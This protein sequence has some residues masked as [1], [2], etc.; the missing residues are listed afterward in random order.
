MMIK[1]TF[2]AAVLTALA[3]M[4][5][6]PGTATLG[7]GAATEPRLGSGGVDLRGHRIGTPSVGTHPLDTSTVARGAP[8]AWAALGPPGGDVTDVAASPVDG[9]LVIAVLASSNGGGGAY[10][11]TD[12]GATWSP[13]AAVSGLAGWQVTF[14]PDGTAYLGTQDG[15][16]IS[17][18]DGVSWTASSL[19]I[20]PNDSV[21]AIT[22]DPSDPDTLWIGISESF[23][24]QPVNVM[25]SND[26]GVT[27]VNRT[28]PLG[29]PL[30]AN[31]IAVDPADGD[32]VIAGFAGGF[33]GGAVWVTTDGGDTWTDRT[34]GL[35]ARPIQ[36]IEHDGE[37][38]LLGGGQL[39]N[40]EFVGLY[41][42]D[43]L[44][45]TWTP[46]HDGTWPLLVVNDVAVDPSDPDT[47]LVATDGSGVHRSEDGGASWTIG[48]EGTG[49]LT[50]QAVHFVPGDPDTVWV[51]ASSLAVFRSTDGGNNFA[52]SA[53]GISELNL[54]S[55]DANPLDTQ[56]LAVCFQGNNNGGV[57]V[58]NDGG[59]SWQPASLPP[60]RYRVV[61]FAPDGTLYALS[62]G[63]TTVAPEGLYRRETD[64]TWTA[65]GPD[66][67]PLFESDLSS[68]RI[69]DVD[70]QRIW[71]GGSDFGV[72]GF[73]QTIWFT[74][75]GGAT[76][77]KQYEG[78]A[79]RVTSD[80]EIVDDGDDQ[81]LVAA[82]DDVSGSDLG[83]ALR[84]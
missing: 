15:V 17:D 78:T 12:G 5:A 66:Q 84:T 38:F 31:A 23:G 37:R 20:G 2:L 42:T 57:L 26:G 83:G 13:I 55:I 29:T 41:A 52:Q 68:V 49:S 53:D 39:F 43:D 30:S 9:D 44:G 56:E 76:W 61:R 24:Q 1:R 18:D 4:P 33:G 81:R 79:N 34:A 45:L 77:V 27:W 48:V 69:S 16:W 82:V 73:E 50:A 72:A 40:S 28:P 7:G 10:R 67:G 59:A 46:L 65:L 58:S 70:P 11:S 14:A 19:G 21:T 80:I 60:T 35:P 22:I 6:F 32:T 64:G 71:L 3:P 8:P 75:D 54:L 62:T 36:A 25:R 47:I 74:D 63:P 51:G